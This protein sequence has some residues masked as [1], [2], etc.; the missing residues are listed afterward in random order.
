MA[1]MMAGD[2]IGGAE[3]RR[4]ADRNRLLAGIEMHQP[5][6][7]AGAAQLPHALFERADARHLAKEMQ[8]GLG[9]QERRVRHAIQII[10]ES[11]GT[12]RAGGIVADPRKRLKTRR[13]GRRL[14][15]EWPKARKLAVLERML[16]IRR[17]EESLVQLFEQ[18]AF[19]AH[20]HLYIGQEATGVAIMETLGPG[21]RLATTHRNHGHVLGRGADPARAMA[22]ILVPHHRPVQRLRRHAASHRT[23]PRLPAYVVDRRR[24]HRPCDRRR[25]RAQEGRRRG[26][27]GRVLRRRLAGGRHL[28]RG[29]EFRRAVVAA[30]PL[31]VREQQ[32][33][34]ARLGQGRLS[35]P[36]CRR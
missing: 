34:R 9:G 23:G 25:V 6:H 31:R 36:R 8:P 27:R 30:D 33:R 13:D 16:V 24:L 17:F 32:P 1:A 21:D 19:M 11:T 10:E 2:V 18:H 3:R 20:Y 29:D 22:E 35:R 7:Q 26:G 15:G 4:N 14:H 12:R 5:R 28:L